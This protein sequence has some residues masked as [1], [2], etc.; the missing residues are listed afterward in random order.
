MQK[1]PRIHDDRHLDFIR[2]LP[3]IITG[4]N[5]TVE[6]AHIRFADLRVDKH[7]AGVGAKPHDMWT[8]PL[9][10]EQHRLQHSMSE[11]KFWRETGIDPIFYALA[12]YAHSGDYE[13]GC[14]IVMNAKMATNILA[15]G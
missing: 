3:C 14:R 2:S 4:E 7:N 12:L 1:Q 8:L 11:R 13:K 9:S 5:T 6:A 15:A 10:G